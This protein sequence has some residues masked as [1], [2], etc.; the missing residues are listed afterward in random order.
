[1]TYAYGYRV[2]ERPSIQWTRVLPRLSAPA[3]AQK[4]A[5]LRV[6]ALV[7]NLAFW[8]ILIVGTVKIFG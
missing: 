5:W 3:W 7:L 1:M 6:G 2:V 8:A 4:V